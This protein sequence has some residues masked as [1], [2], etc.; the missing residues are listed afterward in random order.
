M[1]SRD[2][3]FSLNREWGFTGESWELQGNAVVADDAAEGQVTK[4]LHEKKVKI[5]LYRY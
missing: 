4:P 1:S 2:Y 3:F 5:F